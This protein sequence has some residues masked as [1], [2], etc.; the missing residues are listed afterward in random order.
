MM[1]QIVIAWTE[2]TG[3]KP[4]GKLIERDRNLFPEFVTCPEAR[5]CM[6][7]NKGAESDIERA[8]AHA[9]SEREDKP[10]IT[11]KVYPLNE[12]DPLGRAKREMLEAVEVLYQPNGSIHPRRRQPGLHIQAQS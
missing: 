7:L 1:Q 10:D 4:T 9:D 8:Q 5:A 2:M 11:V 3:L 6:W 12:E